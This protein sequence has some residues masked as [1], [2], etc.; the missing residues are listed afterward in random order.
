MRSVN[1]REE[2]IPL[3]VLWDGPLLFMTVDAITEFFY[4][5]WKSKMSRNHHFILAINTIRKGILCQ[6]LFKEVDGSFTE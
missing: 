3:L 4:L 1:E 2:I 6:C 5:M